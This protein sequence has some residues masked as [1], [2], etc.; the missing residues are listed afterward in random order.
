LRFLLSGLVG[1]L[2]CTVLSAVLALYLSRRLFADI[3]RPLRHLASV[4]PR[5]AN[6]VSTG[7]CRKQIAE[8][9]ELGNDFNA[10]LDELEVWHSHLQ[11]ENET[12]AHQA[13]HDSLTGLP[14]RA[15]FEG[16]LS[17]SLRNAERQDERL[18]LLFLDSD[19]FKQINDTLGH[20]VGDEVLITVA[21]RCARNCVSMTW[22]RAW[23]ATSSPCCWR[24][25]R[26]VKMPSA[27]PRRSLPACSCR[28]CWRMAPASPARS[29]SVSP[30]TRTTARPG[31]S[32]QCRRCGDVPGQAQAPWPLASGADGTLRHGCKKHRS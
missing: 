8:L 28:S 2:L 17:R 31:Q 19:H 9:N 20:A 4:A 15:F 11:S 16:R 30:I 13:S 5:A 21:S 25:C 22:W 14:N 12:L 6:A 29:V 32:A 18:A 24:R 26:R 10:L 7:V 23:A 1:I 27:S 3:I